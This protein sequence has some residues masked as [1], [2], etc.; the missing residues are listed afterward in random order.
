MP[1]AASSKGRVYLEVGG[2]R[3]FASAADWPGWSRPGKTEEAALEAL[4]AYAPRYAAVAKLAKVAFPAV[5]TSFD[6]VERLKGNATT[7][8]G[9]P[10]IPAKEESRPLTPAQTRRMCDLVEASWRYLD[11]VVAKAPAALRKGPRG[12]GRD[13]DVMF[14]HVLGAEI[15]YAKAIGT[16]LKQP[17]R[18]DKAAVRA[19]RQA[20]LESLGDP[21][22]DAKW[23]V[24]YAGRR[25]AWHTLDHAWE[26]EDRSNP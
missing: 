20:I 23:P 21:N 5:A 4:A 1:G 24:P 18:R 14:D 12:G 7:D 8:F 26:I 17:D 16:R 3:T 6:V 2:K 22:R 9:A 11:Q 25:I 15:E 19:F 13:R 10:G